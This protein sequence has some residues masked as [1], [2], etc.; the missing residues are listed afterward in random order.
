MTF[1]SVLPPATGFVVSNSHKSPLSPRQYPLTAA[2]NGIAEGKTKQLFNYYDHET[3]K[4]KDSNWID[5]YYYKKSTG[6]LNP[7]TWLGR[8]LTVLFE[9]DFHA[10]VI[11]FIKGFF[12]F[13]TLAIVVADAPSLMMKSMMV[14]SVTTIIFYNPLKV[15]CDCCKNLGKLM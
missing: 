3:T 8:S 6:Q 10:H 2:E 11:S 15:V 1:P 12:T 13:L 14:F 4:M 5:Q 9:S 7:P